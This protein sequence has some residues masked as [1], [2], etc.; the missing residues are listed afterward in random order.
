[1]LTSKRGLRIPRESESAFPTS[2][3][4]RLSKKHKE[5][6][7]EKEEKKRSNRNRTRAYS[8]QYI[9]QHL[10]QYFKPNLQ[11]VEDERTVPTEPIGP[12]GDEL[13]E[14]PKDTCQVGFKNI[15]GLSI[16][17]G[18]N[19]LPEAVAI[20]A[21]QLDY[22]GMVESNTLLTSRNL[23]TVTAHLEQFVGP[24]KLVYSSTI[25]LHQDTNYSPGGTILGVVGD[26]TGRVQS[27]GADEWG[28]FS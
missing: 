11:N 24:T 27:Y 2:K 4:K 18:F 9:Q 23:S 1:M 20:T 15:M 6:F 14:K 10:H 19:V 28:Q 16:K 7:T 26:Q 21:L 25:T 12:K 22:A 3:G 8:Q 17:N 13:T 5:R